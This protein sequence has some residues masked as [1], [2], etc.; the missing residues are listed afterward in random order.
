VVEHTGTVRQAHPPQVGIKLWVQWTVASTVCGALGLLVGPFIA[1]VILATSFAV[2]DPSLGASPSA[3]PIYSA[4]SIIIWLSALALGTGMIGIVLGA[5]QFLVLKQQLRLSHGW[6]WMTTLGWAIGLPL[7]WIAA[8]IGLSQLSSILSLTLVGTLTGSLVGVGQ[9]FVL[10]W[11]VRH[12]VWWIGSTMLAFM[13]SWYVGALLL[14]QWSIQS[15]WS[16]SSTLIGYLVSGAVSG[17]IGGA[18]T[19]AMLVRLVPTVPMSGAD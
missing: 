9:W 6:I 16:I 10:L 18:I 3:R 17:L 14:E 1:V 5:G 15:T 11:H 19:G 2:I 7:G 4:V 8:L 12:P 13:A